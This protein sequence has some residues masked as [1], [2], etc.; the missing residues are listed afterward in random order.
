MRERLDPLIAER[1]PWLFRPSPVVGLVRKG[2]NRTLGY[3]RTVEIAT[4]L[5]HASTAQIMGEMGRMLARIHHVAGFD[6][7]DIEFVL[8]GADH[9]KPCYFCIDFNQMRSH[10]GDAS[11]LVDSF[12]ANDPYYPRPG[13]KHWGGFADGYMGEA[14]AAGCTNLAQEFLQ[15]VL[16]R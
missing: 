12:F 7:R 4:V 9:K 8:G 11:A 13:A 2:L 5:E 3:D 15:R 16:A 6:G 14:M 1:A 10:G